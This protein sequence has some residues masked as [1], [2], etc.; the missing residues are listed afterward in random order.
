MSEIA[1]ALLTQWTQFRA[2][3]DRRLAEIEKTGH[4][5]A[6]QVQLVDRLNDA[7]SSLQDK[8]DSLETRLNR[9][10]AA[11][12]APKDEQVAGYKG[13]LRRG[14]VDAAMQEGTTTEGGYTVPVPMYGDVLQGL[15]DISYFRRA[16]ARI[17]PMTKWKMDV[18]TLTNSTAAILT[19]EEAG[20]SEVEPTVGTIQAVAYKYTKLVKAS[21]ELVADAAFDLW[22]VI[23]SPDFAQ[24]FAKAENAAFTSGTG[25]SQPQGITAGGTSAV[26]AAATTAVTADE[27]ISCFYAL[28]ERHQ[29]NATW[30]M[31]NA[32]AKAIRQLK[33]GNGQYL[34]AAG[35]AGAPQSILG[36]P[37][38]INNVMP[39]MTTGLKPIIVGN[40]AYYWIFDRQG[41]DLQRL[42]ELYAGN[43]Q[44]GFLAD[45]RFD[46]H[47]MLATAFQYIT[48]A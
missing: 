34:W 6:E 36:A 4:G 26:T 18:P 27:V 33:D 24:A 37:L 20:V 46:G 1:D 28:D 39:A 14:I 13:W 45:K 8:V 41:M 23:L 3:N 22:G 17:V 21:K 40:F 25:S 44:V 10:H 30:M 2:E 31:L 43:G 38:I 15:Q 35:F 19:A 12:S 7:V 16:G 42:V 29:P 11:P 32:T 48:M 5:S 9:P 47:V